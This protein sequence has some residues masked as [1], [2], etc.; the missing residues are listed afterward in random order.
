MLTDTSEQYARAAARVAVRRKIVVARAQQRAWHDVVDP[1]EG[2]AQM[3][4]WDAENPLDARRKRSI[5]DRFEYAAE[6]PLAAVW[7]K[8][9]VNMPA[10]PQSAVQSVTPLGT[11]VSAVAFAS[12]NGRSALEGES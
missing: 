4:R 5:Q 1:L 2:I 3:A 10:E 12:V 11:A 8:L 9:S 6:D 7:K